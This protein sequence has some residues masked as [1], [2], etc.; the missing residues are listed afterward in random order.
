MLTEELYF[1][2]QKRY[3]E[4]EKLHR[5]IKKFKSLELTFPKKTYFHSGTEISVTSQRI[6]MLNG[7]LYVIKEFITS[8]LTLGE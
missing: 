6:S 2:A 7:T 5:K 3:S 1:T 8:I 4:F